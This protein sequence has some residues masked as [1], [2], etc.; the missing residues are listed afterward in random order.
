MILKSIQ[1]QNDDV[2][3]VDS[4]PEYGRGVQFSPGFY[5]II[6]GLILFTAL[7]TWVTWVPNKPLWN[8]E[9]LS[10]YTAAAPDVTS[11]LRIQQRWPVSLDPPGYHLIAHFFIRLPGPSA[12]LVRLPSLLGWLTMLVCLFLFC[13]RLVGPEFAA[14]TTALTLPTAAFSYAAEARPYGLVLGMAAVALLCWQRAVHNRNS[15]W[16]PIGLALALW[17][18]LLLHYLA[19]LLLIPFAL[20]EFV[21]LVRTNSIDWRISTAIASTAIPITTWLPFLQAASEYRAHSYETVRLGQII[22]TYALLMAPRVR[23]PVEFLVEVSVI[24]ATALGVFSLFRRYGARSLPLEWITIIGFALLPCFGVAVAFFATG[25]FEERYVL[26]ALLGIAPLCSISLCGLLI[27]RATFLLAFGIVILAA[28]GTASIYASHDGR[29][30]K[31]LRDTHIDTSPNLAQE[32]LLLPVVVGNLDEYLK[33]QYYGMRNRN[34]L[35]VAD[36]ERENRWVDNDTL[37]R[38]AVNLRRFAPIQVRGFCEFISSN[39]RFLLADE[40]YSEEWLPS[41]LRGDGSQFQPIG[42]LGTARLYRVTASDTTIRE[43]CR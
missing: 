16:A 11:V 15:R 43:A 21:R 36:V 25:G 34:L 32:A 23:G 12:V 10:L 39:R 42:S 33:F 19:L 9:F 38:T 5:R 31:A 27:H 13:R 6:F 30:L 28:L 40:P 4:H 22:S 26:V 1:N 17:I 35:F 24:A 2:I 41:Q 7:V 8:D 14:F 37:D 3:L 18:A 20:A 29:R